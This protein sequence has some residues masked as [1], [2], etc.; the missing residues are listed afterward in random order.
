[1]TELDYKILD[2]LREDCRRPNT[3]MAKIL[4]VSEGTVRAHVAKL[5]EDGIFSYGI[6]ID[7]K[8]VGSRVRTMMGITTKLGYQEQVAETV[9]SFPFV[10]YVGAISGNHD[11]IIQADFRDNEELFRFVNH[12]LPGIDGILTT[13]ISIEL[14]EFKNP[15]QSLGSN[16][17]VKWVV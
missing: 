1:M 15:V 6:Y 4:G 3:D 13:D 12:V 5:L 11:V 8:R 2:L 7:P 9:S 16:P 17:E 14:K 10:K